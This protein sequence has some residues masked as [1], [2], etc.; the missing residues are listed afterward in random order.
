MQLILNKNNQEINFDIRN[1]EVPIL[2]KYTTIICHSIV[3]IC[4]KYFSKYSICVTLNFTMTQ[5]LWNDM[6]YSLLFL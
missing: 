6:Q 4:S 1:N 3:E 5:C 2:W